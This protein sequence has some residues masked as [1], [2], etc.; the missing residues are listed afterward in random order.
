MVASL[1]ANAKPMGRQFFFWAGVTILSWAV[2]PVLAKQGAGHLNGFEMTFWINLFALPVVTLWILPKVH[3]QNLARYSASSILMLAGVGFLGNLLYQVFYFGS[4][5]SITAIT[6][7]VFGRFGSALFVIASIVFLN[8]RH[9][10]AY[11]GALILAIIG[12][13]LS[14]AKPGARLEI[15][16]TAGFA[17]MT[18]GTLLNTGYN[19]ANNAIKRRFA[20]QNVNLFVYKA[21]T[22]AVIGVWAL[23][24]QTKLIAVGPQTSVNIAP[25]PSDLVA[26]FVIGVF[27]DGIGFLAY[28][29]MLSL[30]DSLKVTLVNSMVAVVQV[31]LAV[32]VFNESASFINAVLAPSLV[33]I[34]TAIAGVLDVR[35]VSRPGNRSANPET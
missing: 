17:L 28:L 12:S 25:H 21:S 22:L 3:R 26:P 33:I 13:V 29:K 6:G 35:S 27:A 32:L 34:P 20:D 1:D 30:S 31:F 14:A 16:L 8:E 19:F 4:Y 10:K 9:S 15:V 23:L 24:A 11:I 2:V 18:I 5:Q 7:S